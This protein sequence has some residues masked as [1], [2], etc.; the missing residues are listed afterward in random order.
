MPETIYSKAGA[1]TAI[2][3]A[4]TA[5]GLGTA[6]QHAHGDY[7]T[8]AQGAKAAATEVQQVTLTAPLAYTL[9]VGVPAGVVHR[10]VFTQDATGGHTVTYGGSPVTVDMTAGASTL[11][12]FWPGGDVAYPSETV[13]AAD[14]TDATP[15]GRALLT[16]EDTSAQRTILDVGAQPGV[17]AGVTITAEGTN[18]RPLAIIGQTVYGHVGAALSASVDDGLTWVSV[19]TLPGAPIKLLGCS[20]GEVLLVTALVIRKSSGW[21]TDPSTATWTT[22]VS[23]YQTAFFSRFSVDGDGTKF[24]ATEYGNTR[25]DS[26]YVH[27]STD[28]GDTWTTV[29]DTQAEFPDS[30]AESH[31]HGC[32]YDPWEDRFWFAE[33]HGAPIGLRYSD[34]DGATWHLIPHAGAFTAAAPTVLVAT[35][36]GIVCGTDDHP[37][38][39]VGIRRTESSASLKAEIAFQFWQ[40]TAP[41]AYGFAQW[42][43]RDPRTGIVYMGWRSEYADARPVIVAG[44]ASTGAVVWDSGVSGVSYEVA[45]VVITAGGVVLAAIQARSGAHSHLRA[46]VGAPG[47]AQFT[48]QGNLLGGVAAGGLCVAA[49][50]T[51]AASGVES[52]AFGYGAAATGTHATAVGRGATAGSSGTALGR[53][54]TASGSATAVGTGATASGA[55]SSATGQGSLASGSNAQAVGLNSQATATEA[56][57]IGKG[58][59]SSAGH[60]VAIGNNSTSSGIISTAIGAASD[61]TNTRSTAIGYGAQ[62]THASSVALGAE[63]ATNADS[64]VMMGAIHIA[65]AEV[66]SQPLAA[67]DGARLY[68]KDNGAGKTQLVV[69]FQ[70]GGEVVLATEA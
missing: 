26:R 24:I 50:L 19:Q 13:A 68:V 36:D 60:A 32:C 33:G 5:L 44:T 38:G 63:K 4:I 52:T 30:H 10:V 62:S 49:G 40:G 43:C 47:A 3:D 46:K 17:L 9:P 64:Q 2:S 66:S 65:L 12:E 41:G 67:A 8:A 23:T 1:D 15:A 7:A 37:N 42:G 14:I 45:V 56:L 70:S 39:I 21:A 11:V 54:A 20:D 57:A 59:V 18:P 48:N 51:A 34:D 29:W 61:A 53:G 28:M 58:A 25:A 27:I 31:V 55:S 16:A 6:A 35:N 69:R 22:V